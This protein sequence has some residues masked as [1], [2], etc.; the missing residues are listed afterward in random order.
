[1]RLGDWIGR[2]R[3]RGEDLQLVCLSPKLA[4]SVGFQGVPAVLGGWDNKVMSRG[5]KFGV[6]DL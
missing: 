1:M 4:E 6:E 5:R 2:S 3:G